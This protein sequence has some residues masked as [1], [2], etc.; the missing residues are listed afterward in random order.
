M[1]VQQ[2]IDLVVLQRCLTYILDDPARHKILRTP[3][4]LNIPTH[5]QLMNARLVLP[6]NLENVLF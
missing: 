3:R 1:E 6:E 2:E 4:S 5:K